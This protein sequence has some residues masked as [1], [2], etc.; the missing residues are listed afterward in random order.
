LNSSLV[1]LALSMSRCPLAGP[2][3]LF[4]AEQTGSHTYPEHPGGEQSLQHFQ[5]S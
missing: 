1:R 3:L 2:T 4:A 5:S